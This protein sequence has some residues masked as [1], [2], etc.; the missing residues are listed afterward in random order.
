MG[1]KINRLL[2]KKLALST[3]F[4]QHALD[5]LKASEFITSKSLYRKNLSM[6]IDLFAIN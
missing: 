2:L 6:K 4:K 5:M 1:R 3:Y